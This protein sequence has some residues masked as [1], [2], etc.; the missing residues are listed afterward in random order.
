M[1]I[2]RGRIAVSNG[3][4]CNVRREPHR[5]PVGTVIRHSVTACACVV[6][7]AA[8]GAG[9]VAWAEEAWLAKAKR[10]WMELLEGESPCQWTM[11]TTIREGDR[12]VYYSSM[13]VRRY[14]D[15]GLMLV[16]ETPG[17]KLTAESAYSTATGTMARNGSYVF[18]LKRRKPGAGWAVQ[19]LVPH[20][21]PE[22][23]KLASLT[24][25]SLNCVKWGGLVFDQNVLLPEAL[26]TGR[27]R[28]VSSKR[29]LEEGEEIYR[30]DL[31][32]TVSTDQRLSRSGGRLLEPKATLY[33]DPSKHW[34]IRR[35]VYVGED[36]ETTALYE[37]DPERGYLVSRT[38]ST[39]DTAGKVIGTHEIV[40]SDVKMD[41]DFDNS[42]FRLT[43]FGIPEPPE[44]KTKGFGLWIWIVGGAVLI[45][46]GVFLVMR[47]K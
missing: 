28:I 40:V 20:N 29:V 19:R 42:A 47:R 8:L 1:F 9:R 36:Y 4:Q 5:R 37:V 44:L 33:L 27:T 3:T 12:V 7:V 25:F 31:E 17:A 43:A 2:G 6:L 30:V 34:T 35:A 22:A 32:S 13:L 24:A 10:A 16:S 41:C 39:K 45:C 46:V 11:T 38:T 21:N 14:K 15:N 23:N 26:E 18:E